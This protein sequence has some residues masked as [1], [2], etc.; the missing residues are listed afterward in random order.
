M[1]NL[2][3]KVIPAITQ[4]QERASALPGRTL[5]IGRLAFTGFGNE[6]GM[7]G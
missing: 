1:I 5:E 4:D 2:P 6:G 7:G 3:A